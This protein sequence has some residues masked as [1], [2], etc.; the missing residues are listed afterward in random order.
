VRKKVMLLTWEYPP[1]NLSPISRYCRD[2]SV[3]ISKKMDVL[4]VTFDD[5]KASKSSFK[6]DSEGL[7]IFYV[8]NTIKNTPSPLMWSLT[9]SSEMERVASD[10]F[11]EL[12]GKIDIIHANDWITFPTA[13]ALKKAFNLP[14]VTT[15][16]SIE[17]TRVAG[18][19]PYIEAIKKI[20]WQATYEADKVL[21][22]SLWMKDK[23]M[24]YYQVPEDK[25]DVCVPDWNGWSS[26]VLGAY[27]KVL[28]KGGRK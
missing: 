22:N 25:I 7:Y 28:A 1:R 5:W 24:Q 9:L 10:A 4:V 14:L 19:D 23:V 27:K 12:D 3:K 13:I 11:H 8:E 6:M 21:V 2:L 16:H 15:L 17:P 18:S 20:E 26:D